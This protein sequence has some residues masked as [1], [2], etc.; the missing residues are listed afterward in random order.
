MAQLK[1]H[2]GR[3]AYITGDGV[4]ALAACREAAELLSQ[5][6]PT[7]T[8]AMVLASLGQIQ[9]IAM[10]DVAATDTCKEA[11]VIAQ[12]VGSLEIEAHALNSLGT[13][14][15]YLGNL[16]LGIE[17]LRN[18][19]DLAQRTDSVEE[20]SRA[21]SNLIDVLNYSGRFDEAAK[22]GAEAVAYSE[23]HGLMRWAAAADL[24]EVGLALY[25][26]GSWADARACLIRA[27]RYRTP[28][29]AEIMIEGRTALLD[30]AEGKF[31]E[32]TARLDRLNR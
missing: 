20:V 7:V 28:G 27:E 29:V 13:A 23:Q 1:A 6:P 21:L 12:A 24:S 31:D 14:N 2:L 8:K 4:T 5:S 3:L 11:I 30:V 26:S 16:D 18:S 15:V 19:L 9:M 22:V 17:Q 25:R 32:A 10:H